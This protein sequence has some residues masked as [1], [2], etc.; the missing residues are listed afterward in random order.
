MENE[1]EWNHDLQN[2]VILFNSTM[3][4]RK[5]ALAFGK[6]SENFLS[7]VSSF[8]CGHILQSQFCSMLSLFLEISKFQLPFQF[9]Q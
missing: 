1:K 9:L 5:L 6:R 2:L 3:L 4:S 7:L 8:T